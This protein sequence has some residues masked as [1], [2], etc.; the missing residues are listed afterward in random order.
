[1]ILTIFSFIYGPLVVFLMDSF[2]P[3]ESSFVIL[4]ISIFLIFLHVKDKSPVWIIPFVYFLISLSTLIF[5]KTVWL[6]FGPL[7]ISI[8]VASL[9]SLKDKTHVMILNAINKFKFIK[10]KN[11]SK[12]Q[13]KSN[14]LIWAGAAWANVFLHIVFLAF[15]QK[16]IWAFYVSVGWYS[17]FIVAGFLHIYIWQHRK[18]Q[19]RK[20]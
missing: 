6:K 10:K 7:I 18:K 8:G 4:I 5:G 1:M 17:V 19:K 9:L 12:E 16:W 13:I 20:L 2:T 3:K 15:S 14:S 11:F